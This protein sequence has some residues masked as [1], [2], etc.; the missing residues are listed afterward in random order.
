[1][2]QFVVEKLECCYLQKLLSVAHN[3]I[4]R[5]IQVNYH[6]LNAGKIQ[7]EHIKPCS[8]NGSL[9]LV[10]SRRDPDSEYQVDMAFGTCTCVAGK[11]G[12]PCS[13]QSAVALHFRVAFLNIIPTL[14]PTCRRQMA[15]IAVG[16]EANHDISF[17]ALVSQFQDETKH[18]DLVDFNMDDSLRCWP[19]INSTDN[20]ESQDS[21]ERVEEEIRDASGLSVD[22]E[23]VIMDLKQCMDEGDPQLCSGV[24]NFFVRYNTMV[25]SYSNALMA[26]AFHCFGSQHN[27]GTVTCVQGSG[28][29]RG[30]WIP[31]QATA[32]GR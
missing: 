20:I 22:L 3:H 32:S 24:K 28:I 13:H 9:F 15:F 6:G 23:S 8:E 18:P 5:Y 21:D 17:Y 27:P 31:V 25:K 26:S 4:D 1:M 29:Q 10:K 7:K 12:S 11:D 19:N 16:E 30:R 14:H 2:F